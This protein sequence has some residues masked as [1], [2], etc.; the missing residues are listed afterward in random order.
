MKILSITLLLTVLLFEV[1]PTQAQD[2]WGEPK[3][4]QA[5]SARI[6]Y[7]VVGKGE[8]LLLVHGFLGRASNWE[9]YTAALS[10][11]HQLILVDLRGH[12]YSTN[13]KS[14]YIFKD[15]A[16]DLLAVLDDVG[17]VSTHAAGFSAG[18]SALL[19][20]AISYPDRLKSI[21]IMG[22]P[23]Q[24]TDKTVS[25]FKSFHPDSVSQTFLEQVSANHERGEAQTR[26]LLNNLQ[27]LAKNTNEQYTNIQLAA[28]TTPT[29]IVSGDRDLA[30]P[31]EQSLML[32]RTIPNAYLMVMPNTGHSMAPADDQGAAYLTSAM[33]GF[34]SNK[35]TCP[36]FCDD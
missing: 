23:T 17:V 16:S 5:D 24:F 35:W 21:V 18:S 7:W 30:V 32:Y 13:E 10:K 11:N 4:A 8:P 28:M 3:Y 29:L 19:R 26:K 34:F 20:M 33:L 12:G 22:L 6:A 2:S 1:V 36:A 14:K 15:S 31:V 27:Q 25:L 9:N